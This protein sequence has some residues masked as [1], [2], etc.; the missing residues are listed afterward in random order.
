ME[1]E[2]LPKGLQKR[3]GEQ[4]RSLPAL[5]ACF[6]STIPVMAG[7]IFL[8]ITY[9]ILMR[10]A[11]FPWW[12]AVLQAFVIYTGSME[13]LMVSIL[14]SSFNPVSAAVT[15]FMVGARHIFY[16]L[17]MLSKY[18]NTG[19]KKFYLIY[20]TSDETFAVNYSAKIPDHIDHGWFYF[21]VS[22]LDQM[23]WASGA[24]IGGV[25]G[26]ILSR[27]INTEGLDFV[28]TAM[29]TVI[30]MDQ[31]MKDR[32][33]A[34]KSGKG[35]ASLWYHLPSLIG[36]LASVVCLLIFGPDYFIVPTMI[37]IFV[38]LMIGRPG[39]EQNLTISM[40]GDETSPDTEESGG[41]RQE[42]KS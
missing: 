26:G 38:L 30:F 29:F 15:A 14:A 20:T 18:R 32:D 13:F 34:K 28:M 4:G 12:L 10:T 42:E 8:G 2:R 27:M 19:R 23:Y 6:K 22:F 39:L 11:G 3:T 33:E 31:W 37:L 40:E 35:H 41:I 21:W 17:S 16:G 5:K 36:V 9:G 25:F 7:Y 1:V 24:L